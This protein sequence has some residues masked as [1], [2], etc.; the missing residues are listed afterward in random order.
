VVAAAPNCAPFYQQSCNEAANA[1]NLWNKF[2]VRG[3]P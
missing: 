2:V 3:F 1:L